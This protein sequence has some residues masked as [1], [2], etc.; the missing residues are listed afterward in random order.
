MRCAPSAPKARAGR[1]IPSRPRLPPCRTTTRARPQVQ[2]ALLLVRVRKSWVARCRM[3][4]ASQL[5]KQTRMYSWYLPSLRIIL[6]PFAALMDRQRSKGG[7]CK[8][9]SH[10]HV[11][12]C[13]G[14]LIGRLDA[15]VLSLFVTTSYLESNAVQTT[16]VILTLTTF[17]SFRYE[18]DK[19]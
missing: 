6:E 16:L 1:P 3:A 15:Y 13:K 19:P 2:L 4:P 7:V 14:L 18:R 10:C 5:R 17:F 12:C 11:T 8:A 9:L